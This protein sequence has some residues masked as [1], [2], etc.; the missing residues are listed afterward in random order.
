MYIYILCVYII[1]IIYP[2]SIDYN[3]V[4]MIISHSFNSIE[5]KGVIRINVS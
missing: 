3:S 4:T 1:T 5:W 2:I